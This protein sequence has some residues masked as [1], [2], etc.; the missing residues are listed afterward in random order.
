[1]PWSISNG[2]KLRKTYCRLS[3]NLLVSCHTFSEPNWSRYRNIRIDAVHYCGKEVELAHRRK[4]RSTS[5]R[6]VGPSHGRLQL[7]SRTVRENHLLAEKVQY[8]K[9]PYMTREGSVADLARTVA[10]LPNLRYVDLPDAFYTDGSSCMTLKQELQSRCP[11][12]RYMKYK[13]GSE[14]SFQLLS[15]LTH[16]EELEA[17]ELCYLYLEG[18]TLI[19]VL[20]SLRCIEELTLANMYLLDDSIF[21]S[22]H[23]QAA[24]PALTKL[25]LQDLPQISI[26]GLVTYLSQSGPRNTLTHLTLV[27]MGHPSELHRILPEAPHLVSLHIATSVNRALPSTQIPWLSSKSLRLLHYEISDAEDSLKGVS[28]PSESYYSYLSSSF[29]NGSLPSLLQLYALSP[30]LQSS[31][32]PAPSL[33]LSGNRSGSVPASLSSGIARPLHL[34]TKSVSEMEWESTVVLPQST[35]Q[36]RANAVKEICESR[37]NMPPLSPL[38]R[39][40]GRQSVIVS[41]G[42]GGLLAVPNDENPPGS[43]GFRAKKDM[44]AWMG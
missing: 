18:R 37:Y 12:L 38:Y 24:F 28:S 27:Q 34:Y 22:S 10:F 29:L 26:D 35:G 14:S 43:P 32:Q 39:S 44:N 42:F 4:R 7:L 13:A 40:Q 25:T 30:T 9:L 36:G 19:E 41:N 5:G 8:L 1:M 2:Q 31:L 3:S 11:R 17:I 6:D 16:W 15:H 33:K 20:A 21:D 23:P